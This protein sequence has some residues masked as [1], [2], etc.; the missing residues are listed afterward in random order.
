MSRWTF[1]SLLGEAVCLAAVVFALG[2]FGAAARPGVHGAE[3]RRR[4]IRADR[5]DPGGPGRRRGPSCA[6]LR[7]ALP[8]RA[9]TRRTVA[10]CRGWRGRLMVRIALTLLVL[11]TGALLL[12]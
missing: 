7:G 12:V 11:G 4:P 3:R 2:A 6:T 10:G 8:R 1:A 5:A 9:A